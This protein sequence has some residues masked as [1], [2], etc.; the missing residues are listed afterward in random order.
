MDIV[1]VYMDIVVVYMDV[2]VVYMDIVVMD[3][4]PC[5]GEDTRPAN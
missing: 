5:S 3:F 4:L 1:V 2:V